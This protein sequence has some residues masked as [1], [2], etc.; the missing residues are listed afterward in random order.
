MG[1]PV[2]SKREKIKRKRLSEE[3][4]KGAVN[5]RAVGGVAVEEKTVEE[6]RLM[7]SVPVGGSLLKVS[8]CLCW[9]FFILTLT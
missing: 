1:I 9:P 3:G 4:R 6:N 7:A 2:T 5:G 8:R